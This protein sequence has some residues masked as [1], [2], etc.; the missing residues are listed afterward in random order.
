MQLHS[1]VTRFHST[2]VQQ[3]KWLKNWDVLHK[4]TSVQDQS[5]KYKN[6]DLNTEATTIN[7]IGAQ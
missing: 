2:V 7:C 1:S 5:Q 4:S 3:I 6:V